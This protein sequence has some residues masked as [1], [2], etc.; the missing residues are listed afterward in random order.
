MI[1]GIARRPQQGIWHV[2][3]TPV[4]S[5]SPAATGNDQGRVHGVTPAELGLSAALRSLARGAQ[6]GSNQR[7]LLCKFS[8]PKSLTCGNATDV[9]SDLQ[10]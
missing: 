8:P 4:I 7:H 5:G 9:S 1:G 10:K 6:L 3:G 2:A